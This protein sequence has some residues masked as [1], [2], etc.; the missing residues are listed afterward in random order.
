MDSSLPKPIGR[1]ARKIYT[2]S[3]LTR[4]IKGFL[5]SQFPLIWI[6]GEIS[7]L[8]TPTSGHSYFSLKD[9]QAQIRA[10]IF[11]SENELLPCKLEDGLHVIGLGRVSLYEP[12]GEYQIVFEILEP[13]G[14]G[15]LQLA[16]EQ[17]KE[18]LEKEGLFSSERKKPLPFL[19]QRVVVITSPTGAAVRDFLHVLQRRY[20][21]VE[22]LIYPVHV[23]GDES[24]PD[25][26]E[27]LDRIN[28]EL[29][30][31]VVVLTRGGGSLED[32]WS[33]NHE[34][35][36]RAIARSRIPV[37]SAIGHETDFTISDFVADARA[38]TPS[39]AAEIIV[40]PKKDLEAIV[41]GLKTILLHRITGRI[42]LWEER[43]RGLQRGLS[44]PRRSVA[45]RAIRA[46]ELS[47]KLWLG[48]DSWM[49][50]CRRRLQNPL[51]A[52]QEN[53]MLNEFLRLKE[54]IRGHENILKKNIIHFLDGHR[55]NLESCVR[56]L[57]ALN[58]WRVLQ[59][60][61]SIT[62]ML[63]HLHLITDA[64]HVLKN[65]QV[66]VLLSKGHLVCRV[67][68]THYEPAGDASA[69]TPEEIK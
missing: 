61:Y 1:P 18:K 10:I 34:Q 59:R 23:Q 35:V 7:N 52:L 20:A 62:R 26:V 4:E 28:R 22:V 14:Y 69:T 67:E 42:Q 32:L 31:D 60:G 40:R 43:F 3:E 39:A 36:A 51:D 38:P 8:R 30:V 9:G 44:D 2:V 56:A 49:D 68:E 29:A 11:R 63:P 13:K 47:S 16:F 41:D 12:R 21:N 33:F 45:D 6:Q 54:R 64:R 65:D 66:Q 46:D 25:V 24:A 53:T 19:P 17:L 55:S 58:P 57:D 15:A 5:E 27:A 50:K 48:W 37:L